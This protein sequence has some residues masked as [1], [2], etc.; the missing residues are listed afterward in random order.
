MGMM[1]ELAGLRTCSAPTRRSSRSCTSATS[2]TRRASTPSGARYFDELQRRRAAGR[3]ARAGRRVV[4]ASSRATA[5]CTRRDGRR[6]HHAQ[7][8]ARCC[9][10]ITRVPHRS[11]CSRADLDPLQAHAAPTTSPSSSS[12]TTASPTPTWTREFNAGS[13][14]ARSACA[15]RDI[16]AALKETYC[17]TI[18]VEYMYITDTARSAGS[19][20]A[21]SRS[22]RTPSSRAD[23]KRSTS[24]SAS[25]RPRRSSATC[26]PGTSARSASRA[27][28]ARA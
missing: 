23:Q 15:L 25:P 11:A 26:T 17:G 27:R 22:A 6:D 19:R 21:S 10:C 12:R 16:V 8:G 4:R 28:A 7:A 24:S 9:S 18:G 20:S 2:P 13:R 1:K 14:R 5:A 3:G